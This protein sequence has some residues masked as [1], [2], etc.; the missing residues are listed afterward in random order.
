[1]FFSQTHGSFE[2]AAGP[3][4][5]THEWDHGLGEGGAIAPP[6]AIANAVADAF[7]DMRVSFDETPRRIYETVAR[8]RG[9]NPQRMKVGFRQDQSPARTDDIERHLKG[10]LTAERSSTVR[11]S[12]SICCSF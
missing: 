10:V 7:A 1:L 9:P 6:A 5:V 2:T 3:E 12:D 4:T 11:G 8:K